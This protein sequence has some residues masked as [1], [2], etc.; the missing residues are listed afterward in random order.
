[1]YSHVATTGKN[2]IPL[3]ILRDNINDYNNAQ[4][5]RY[6]GLIYKIKRG[7]WGIT[8]I[9][10]QFLKGDTVLAKWVKIEDNHIVE[11]SDKLIDITEVYAGSSAIATEFEYF[12]ND[13]PVGLRP[14]EPIQQKEQVELFN[15]PKAI[16]WL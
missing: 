16:S 10:G 5:L 15:E 11:K 1:M 3:N 13:V 8:R 6:H 7:T 12:E 9:G 2:E 4:K 14:I